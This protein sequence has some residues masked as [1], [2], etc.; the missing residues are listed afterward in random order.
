MGRFFLALILLFGLQ[1]LTIPL[2]AAP[3]PDLQLEAPS[4]VFI[5]DQFELSVTFQNTAANDTG[6]GPF[7]DLWLPRNGADGAAGMAAPDGITF[8]SAAYLDLPVHAEVFIFPATQGSSNGCIPHPYLRDENYQ[9]VQVCGTT[10]DQL[11]VLELPFGSVTPGQPSVEVIVTA[12]VSDLADLNVPL[13][14]RTRSGFRFGETPLDDPCCDLPILSPEANVSVTPVLLT[15]A[16]SNDAPES[17]I[18]TGPNFPHHWTITVDV[19]N[20]QTITSLDVSD[21][22]PPGVT[23]VDVVS[24]VP[25]LSGM[26]VVNGSVV[27][28]PIAS[29]TG[30]TGEEDVRIE[31]E[32]FADNVLN[33]TTGETEQIY[34]SMDAV[35]DWQPNDPRDQGT[36]NN[37]AASGACTAASCP[38]GD[39]PYLLALAAQK[40]VVPLNGNVAPGAVLEYTINFQLSDFYAASEV[41]LTDIISDGQ[42]LDSGFTPVLTYT[43]HG[44][45]NNGSVNAANYDVLEYWTGG[46]PGIPA[47]PPAEDGDTVLIMRVSDEVGEPMLGGCIPAGGT[48]APDCGSFNGGATTGTLTYRTIILDEFVNNFP[49][50]DASIDHGDILSNRV[51]INAQLLNPSDFTPGGYGQ[52]NNDSSSDVEITRGE[53]S[54]SLFAINGTPCG[55][56]T[57]IQVAFGDTV[58]YRLGQELFTS[59]FEDFRLVDYLPLPVF[60]AIEITNFAYVVDAA[61]PPAGTAK[62][63]TNDTLFNL[64]QTVRPGSP[65]Y[66]VIQVDPISNSVTFSYGDEFDDPQ[67]RSSFVDILFTVTVQDQPI[68]DGL[69]LTNIVQAQEG[70][71]NAGDSAEETITQVE[72]TAP[73]LLISKGVVATTN[74][75]GQFSPVNPAPVPFNPPGSAAPFDGVISSSGLD[76]T[77]I[78]SNLSGSNAS[79]TVTFA[80]VIENLGSSPAFDIQIQD[81]LSPGFAI[82]SDGLNLQVRLGNGVE[83][84]YTPLGSSGTDRDLFDQGIELIDPGINGVCGPYSDDSGLNIVII[85][86][87]LIVT[88]LTD[89][90]LQNTATITNYASNES[91]TDYTG[92]QL[93]QDSATVTIGTGEGSGENSTGGLIT[94]SVDKPFAQ[95]GEQIT[96]TVEVVN[97]TGAALTDVVVMD[98][99]PDALEPL[100]AVTTHG[101]ISLI[102]Q[103]YQITIGT[104][105]P[106]ET[107]QITI[108][109]RIHPETAPP[110]VL[111]NTA[112]LLIGGQEVDRAEANILSATTMPATG[113]SPAQ[114]LLPAGLLVFGAWIML[115]NRGHFSVSPRKIH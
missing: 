31:F 38:G 88:A 52:V 8:V 37:A 65:Q 111:V 46:N 29:V 86:Y 7:I 91:G 19:P 73:L 81:T 16:K 64:M 59:D 11:V 67:N 6:Y 44:A 39:A 112:I 24:A 83:I 92:D 98:T 42:H 1:G 109:S 36:E 63:Y 82:P 70:S 10:G 4:E 60:N 51:E 101:S 45:S 69:I 71:T 76:N 5:G 49:S 108:R 57:G 103:Q 61:V 15:I 30:G 50:G 105:T 27:T 74:A 9:P 33:P 40:E 26:P 96:W 78:N 80:I 20:G 17:E 90:V 55:A 93:V 41:I 32:F 62:F 34:N 22:L 53:L 72:I 13:P 66:P 12:Q 79:D 85:T 28:F 100:T 68:A 104:L 107:A 2:T 18:P 77:A 102:G 84:G 110:Y 113:E 97:N 48:S 75:N 115:I 23:Y 14:I 114:Y 56:C 25:A 3:L 47:I 21:H 95:P 87:D 106:N 99:L 43:Q 54:K 35:G 94:K 89:Q 58:T